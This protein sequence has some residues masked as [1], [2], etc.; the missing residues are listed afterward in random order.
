MRRCHDRCGAAHSMRVPRP[1]GPF[2]SRPRRRRRS[3]HQPLIQRRNTPRSRQLS[4]SWLGPQTTWT[5][6]WRRAR[7][8]VEKISSMRGQCGSTT[9]R[10]FSAM[11]ILL[12]AQR[13]GCT[14][15]A[16]LDTQPS[17]QISATPPLLKGRSVCCTS[18]SSRWSIHAWMWMSTTCKLNA[19]VRST[20]QGNV[21]WARSSIV[22]CYGHCRTTNFAHTYHGSPCDFRDGTGGS[23][24][25]LMRTVTS[26]RGCTGDHS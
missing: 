15:T 8:L 24:R 18:K 13:D 3:R 16:S 17:R 26:R 20:A 23:L 10:G 2:L 9:T 22:R 4:S 12:I 6:R 14:L 21:A 11:S 25:A 19:Y 5:L 1:I 7:S